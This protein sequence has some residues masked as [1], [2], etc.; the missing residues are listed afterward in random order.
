MWDTNSLLLQ[1]KL[2]TCE[3]PPGCGLLARGTIFV[4]TMSLPLLPILDVVFLSFV[5]EED[6]FS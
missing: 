2:Q 1:E 5:V 3:I 4:E 6:I